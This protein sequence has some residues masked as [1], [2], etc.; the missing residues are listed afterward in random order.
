MPAPRR[1]WQQRAQ[2]RARCCSRTPSKLW[3]RCPAIPRSEASARA[4]SCAKSTRLVARWRAQPTRRGSSSGRL[5]RARG[6]LFGPHEPRPTA[7]CTERAI[8]RRLEAQA[9]LWLFQAAVDDLLVEG[10]RVAGAV[11][12]VGLEFRAATVVLTAGTFLGGLVHVGLSRYQAGRAGDPPSLSLAAR[13]RELRL[14]VGRL[15]TGTPPRIDG[16]SIDFSKLAEQPGDHPEPVFSFTGSRSQHPRQVSC[17][18]THTNERTHGI[19]RGGLDRSPMFTGVIEGIGPRY[20]PSIEDKIHRFAGKASHQI[21]LEPE[22]LDDPR[23]LSQ[24]DFHQPAVRRPARAGAVDR[25]P[26]T[27][28]HPAPWIRDRIRLFRSAVAQVHARDQDDRGP[29]LRRP[30]QRDDGLRG[31]RGAGFAGRDQRG[32]GGPWRGGLVPPARRG[33]SGRDDRRPRHA[34]RD[35]ALPDVHEP[36]GIPPAAARGQCR[37]APYRHRAQ[38][39]P[40]RRRALE[41]IRAQTGCDCVRDRAAQVH[42]GDAVK[43]YTGRSKACVRP[44]H[45]AASTH[46]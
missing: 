24:R 8:R 19:I 36:G 23:V 9:N 16:R 39:R 28:A 29:V 45:G 43:N 5:T 25:R 44:P 31:S 30:D 46:F 33:L 32:A 17:W 4:I 12:S 21:F 34:R 3:A 22:G 15:K 27:G 41:G 26:G 42:M 40:G 2:G 35:R 13:L 10:E 6:R 37:P 38:A 11:T 20:C 1:R 14:P 7:C 18:I